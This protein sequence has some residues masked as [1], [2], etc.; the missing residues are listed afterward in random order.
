MASRHPTGFV[1]SQ[2]RRQGAALELR[3]DAGMILHPR[4][5]VPHHYNYQEE[6][7]SV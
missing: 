6:S 4:F 3:I 2:R 7:I 5:P 1:H